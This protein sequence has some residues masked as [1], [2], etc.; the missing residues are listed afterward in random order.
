MSEL[1]SGPSVY[2][3]KRDNAFFGRQAIGACATRCPSPKTHGSSAC[4]SRTTWRSPGERRR[5]PSPSTAQWPDVGGAEVPPSSWPDMIAKVWVIAESGTEER[6]AAALEVALLC[7][8][9]PPPMSR[10]SSRSSETGLALAADC[11]RPAR[12]AMAALP[13]SARASPG[14]AAA[15]LG[16]APRLEVRGERRPARAWPSR[17]TSK[18]TST[19]SIRRREAWF[20]QSALDLGVPT[21]LSRRANSILRS[22]RPGIC[23]VI[24]RD[25]ARPRD[26][27]ERASVLAFGGVALAVG[28]ERGDIIVYDVAARRKTRRHSVRGAVT[29]IAAT[30]L[31]VA[32]RPE[33]LRRFGGSGRG[34]PERVLSQAVDCCS[35]SCPERASP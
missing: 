30:A 9:T 2:A 14:R 1:F 19:S 4:E 31:E 6:G 34:R 5:S 8:P 17:S 25:G 12:V 7:S 33:S 22:R 3:P 28:S 15:R 32:H 20:S 13:A 29:A 27:A 26:L 10:C 18:G 23:I 24:W 35:R 11:R 16:R 21:A